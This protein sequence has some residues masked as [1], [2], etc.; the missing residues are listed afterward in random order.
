M[1]P[2]ICVILGLAVIT[3]TAFAADAVLKLPGAIRTIEEEVFYGDAALYEVV[4]PS[5]LTRIEG[6]AFAFSSV[7][8]INLPDSIEYIAEDAF[9]GCQLEYA[10]AQSDYCKKWCSDHG[11]RIYP[12]DDNE[13][14]MFTDF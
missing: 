3:G 14:G 2:I 4:L 9:D 13:T 1:K 10:K 6:K 5:G 8:Y 12:S 7:R 11:I